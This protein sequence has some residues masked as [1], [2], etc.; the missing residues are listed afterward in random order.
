MITLVIIL[1]VIAGF[2][3]WGWLPHYRP[4]LQAGESYGIDVSNHQGAVDWESVA[5]DNIDFV[6]IKA[7]EGGDFVD[8]WFARNW[9]GARAAGLDTGAYHFFTLCRSG[10]EQADNFLTTVPTEQTQ[11]PASLD[12]ELAGNCAERPSAEWVHQEVLLWINRVHRATGQEVL[13]YVGPRFDEMYDITETFSE[14]TWHR[15]LW[16]RPGDDRWQVWQLSYRSSVDGVDGGVDLNVGRL[17]APV[18]G[19]GNIL[20][21]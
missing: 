21:T 7:T 3:W 4:G 15:Q 18:A 6:Y 20:G 12:L 14:P 19:T 13:L 2:V 16:R 5:G 9:S 17:E 1:G 11:L 10:A 8:D